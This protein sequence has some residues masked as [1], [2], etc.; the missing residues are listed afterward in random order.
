LIVQND[1]GNQYSTTTIIAAMT[2]M[3]KTSYPF[4]VEF[5]ASD[6]GLEQGGTILLE[7][8]LTISSDRLLK[9]AGTLS[10]E[11]MEAVDKA[12][13]YSLGLKGG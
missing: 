1:K 8:I 4:H 10:A 7:Q 2:S 5:S 13:R 3:S 9:R 11:K 12:L 6:C